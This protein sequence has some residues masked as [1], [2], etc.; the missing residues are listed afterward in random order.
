MYILYMFTCALVTYVDDAQWLNT[1]HLHVHTC[2]ALHVHVSLHKY[3][4]QTMY[5]YIVPMYMYVHN[6][7]TSLIIHSLC[8]GRRWH[9]LGNLQ[10]LGNFQD[11]SVGEQYQPSRLREDDH[12]L[13]H[14][15]H[16]SI[17]YY[18]C[19]LKFHWALTQFNCYSWTCCNY[20]HSNA[21]ADLPGH[22]HTLI[23]WSLFGMLMRT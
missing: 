6:K 19:L 22:M 20:T 18:T 4:Q 17:T 10:A 2:T 3:V 15:M 12:K 23:S 8:H 13:S 14:T 21:V 5:I 16:A 11:Y 1:V 9:Q 7:K